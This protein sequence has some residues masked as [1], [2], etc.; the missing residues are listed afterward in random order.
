MAT[1]YRYFCGPTEATLSN[2]HEINC[3]D[4]DG[5][6]I[7]KEIDRLLGA[8][9]ITPELTEDAKKCHSVA[10]NYFNCVERTK[11][12][13]ELPGLRKKV[14]DLTKKYSLGTPW[15][16]LTAGAAV[17]YGLYRVA[18]SPIPAILK[19]SLQSFSFFAGNATASAN[20]TA[21]ANTTLNATAAVNATANWGAT[22]LGVGADGL[23]SQI[24]PALAAI[25]FTIG[26]MRLAYK[27]L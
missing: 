14:E 27:H 5:K 13:R 4:Y 1:I 8:K 26:M 22:L 24:L 11:E 12:A 21:A 25:G 20:V 9:G 18:K 2:G 15:S 23:S 3:R 10:L 6:T 19:T 16:H 17:L 7:E